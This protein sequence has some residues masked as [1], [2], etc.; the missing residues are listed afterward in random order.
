M[1]EKY[2]PIGSV[3]SIPTSNKKVMITGYYGVDYKGKVN[4][5]DYKGVTYPEGLLSE[6]ISFVF[7]HNEISNIDF[8]GYE[9][10]EYNVLNNNLNGKDEKKEQFSF[11]SSGVVTFDGKNKIEYVASKPVQSENI[12]PF[13][14]NIEVESTDKVDIPLYNFDSNGMVI[15]ENV[16]KIEEINNQDYVFDKKSNENALKFDSNGMVISDEE[17]KENNEVFKESSQTTTSNIESNIKFDSNGM[18]ISENKENT[19][20]SNVEILDFEQK[21]GFKFDSNGMVVSE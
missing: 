2:L 4:F 8:I 14:Q 6:N 9:T 5:Y 10:E 20:D 11:D 17:E 13:N 16:V 3:I 18:V 12:N 21:K 15:S 19:N 7:N 1:K